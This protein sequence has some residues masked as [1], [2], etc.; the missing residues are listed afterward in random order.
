MLIY[1]HVQHTP[2]IINY[3]FG[4]PDYPVK[5]LNILLKGKSQNETTIYR[6]HDFN[7]SFKSTCFVDMER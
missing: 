1:I 4:V 2:A 5:F 3:K 7:V 6:V